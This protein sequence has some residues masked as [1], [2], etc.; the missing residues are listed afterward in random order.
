MAVD[1]TRNAAAR[2]AE[3]ERNE[4]QREALMAADQAAAEPAGEGK[5]YGQLVVLGYKEYRVEGSTWHP[6]GSRNDKFALNRR[7][8]ANGIKK[9]QVYLS[10]PATGRPLR[11]QFASHSVTMSVRSSAPN[12]A[13]SVMQQVTIEYVPDDT[14]DMFQL[15][16]M[17]VPQNDFVVRGPLH[18]DAN[19]VLCGPVS[20]YACRI[21]CSRLPPFDCYIFAA[22][23][24][25]E[26][27]I[28]LSEQAPKWRLS[29]GGG[30]GAVGSMEAR[31]MD[32]ANSQSASA[33]FGGGGGGGGGMPAAAPPRRDGSA[34][35]EGWDALTTFGVRIWKPEV[36][37]WRE[38]SVN[39][40]IHEPRTQPSRQGGLLAAED[41]RLTN[42]TIIDLAGIQL[43]FESAPSM[44]QSARL[45]PAD[46]MA[47]FNARKPQCPVQ[48]HTIRFEYDEAK[49]AALES[50]RKPFI[51]PA[52]GHVHAYAPELQRMP[53]PLCRKR[54][55]FVE[56]KLEWEPAICKHPPTV[57]FN[58]CGHIVSLETA[59]HWARLAL[60][61][62]APPNARYRPIC[63]FCAK[64]LKTPATPATPTSAS[65]AGPEERPYNRILFQEPGEGGGDDADQLRSGVWG[66]IPPDEGDELADAKSGDDDDEAVAEAAEA[67]EAAEDR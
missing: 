58:P 57:A 54:G 4:R 2:A 45:Q 31:R 61:D 64:P 17:V 16:R 65:L 51:F 5:C 11:S 47:N 48:M 52:C 63:P 34:D 12:G 1:E 28:F 50:D 40:S 22:G 39:G 19:G 37:E 8:T 53:C 44:A 3:A 14:T 29:G 41:S 7:K 9:H 56:L 42:G 26:R 38:V 25:N 46:I 59:E 21:V 23:F 20:R 55:P 18:M 35:N 32:A 49:R 60:P 15:G 24:N 6:V 10:A 36:G 67:A 33:S 30:G 62:N 43:L 13:G 66:A 27:D